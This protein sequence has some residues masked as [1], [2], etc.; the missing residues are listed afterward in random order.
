MSTSTK[1][2]IKK[3]SKK[4][5]QRYSPKIYEEILSKEDRPYSCLLVKQYGYLICVPFRTEIR[6]KYAY[7]FQ[8][9]KRSG[10]HHS[11]LD[12]TKAVIV[13]NQEFIN[14]GIVVVDQDEYKEVI[15][16]I[17]KIVDSVIKFVD[18]YVEHIKGIK[19]L[20]ERE[21]ERRYH[22]SS[23][24]YF[25]REL[26][27]SQKKELEEEGMLRDNVKKYYLEQDY[28][29]AETILRCI[30]EEYGIGLTEDDFKLVS[31]FGG[32]MGCGSS[33]GALCG[34]MAALGLLTV[35]TRAHA[36]DGF[37]DTCADL[38]E[39]FRNKLGNTD[40]SELVKVYKKDDVRCLETV[41][42]A[43]DVFEEFYNTYIAENKIG[44][45][46]EM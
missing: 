27:L 4:F 18:D 23:L 19:K 11:G 43:A 8:A 38:V 40:C 36:T 39:A 33:C 10:K 34:A 21:F 14:E 37:K 3:L 16:N 20:H 32:G 24:K 22:F 7:H 45:I 35:N 17:E 28:N 44:K 12:F 15:Y 13:T 31:A 5:Y 25:E 2:Y 26:G 6:H 30:D 41:C 1:F 9:S 29:C 42:L 46:K